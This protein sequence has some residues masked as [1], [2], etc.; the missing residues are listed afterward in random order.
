[1]NNEVLIV[2]DVVI[3][4]I[5]FKSLLMQLNIKASSASDGDQ[6]INMV[7]NK[8]TQT[9]TSFKLILMDYSMPDKNGPQVAKEI[10]E[11]LGAQATELQR[12]YICCVSAYQD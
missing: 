3:N 4:I 6:A 2:D 8:Y 10:L 1:M 11:Y 5:A 9:G 12:P 7:K